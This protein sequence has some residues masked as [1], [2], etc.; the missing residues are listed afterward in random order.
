MTV[1]ENW[2]DKQMDR[3]TRRGGNSLMTWVMGTASVRIQ[4][5]PG[6]CFHPGRVIS[7][8]QYACTVNMIH[9]RTNNTATPERK[10]LVRHQKG[11][12]GDKI[13]VHRR[14]FLC[15]R[16]GV[17]RTTVN[18]IEILAPLL[19]NEFDDRARVSEGPH[20]TGV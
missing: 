14:I 2:T 20:Q 17:I 13:L 9:I 8:T 4:M 16:Q 10:G 19:N 6:I 15:G 12:V 11:V 5:D 18:T 3:G 1:A 7:H